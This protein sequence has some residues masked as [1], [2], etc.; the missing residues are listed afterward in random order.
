MIPQP[1]HT[2]LKQLPVIKQ[3]RS[4]LQRAGPQNLTSAE[5]IAILLGAGTKQVSA[6]QLAEKILHRHHQH[7]TTVTFNQLQKFRGIGPVRAAQLLAALELGRRYFSPQP[8]QQILKPQ[9]VLSQVTAIRSSH[10]EHLLVLYLNARYELLAKQTIAIGSLNTN[11]V[12]ARDIFA[13]A[14]TLPCRSL[15]LVHNHPSGNA[16]PSYDDL[17]TTKKLQA[18]GELLGIEVADHLIVTAQSHHSF[19]DSGLM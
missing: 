10:R 15:I 2:T 13:Q 4:I 5:L 14:I 6:K 8:A 11:A 12:E 1:A 3:P 7:L 16:Q 18:A 19:R 17:E 9:D